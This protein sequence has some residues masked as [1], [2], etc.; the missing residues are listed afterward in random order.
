MDVTA[1]QEG[2][3]L[4]GEDIVE[5]CRCVGKGRMHGERA[6]GVKGDSI[7][8]IFACADVLQ[9]QSSTLAIEVYYVVL[10]QWANLKCRE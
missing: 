2:P 6:G 8:S 3:A 10:L 9:Q 5:V 7:S 4:A 1:T